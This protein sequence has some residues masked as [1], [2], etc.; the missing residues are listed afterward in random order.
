MVVYCL[1]PF[2]LLFCLVGAIW[3]AGWEHPK[4]CLRVFYY[5]LWWTFVGLWY[6]VIPLVAIVV[7][8]IQMRLRE[9][10]GKEPNQASEAIGAQ[11]APQPQR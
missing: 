3:W 9:R 2:Y 8:D 5:F 11:S 10:K 4:S 6:I 7:L 1:L